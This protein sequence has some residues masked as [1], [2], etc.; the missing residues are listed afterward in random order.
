[1]SV[2]KQA[3]VLGL[4]GL[5][6]STV[7]AEEVPL[8]AA[9]SVQ[10][11][12]RDHAGAALSR[13]KPEV[14]FAIDVEIRNEA[15]AEPPSGLELYGWLRRSSAQNLPCLQAARGYFGTGRL[16]LDAVPLIG[17]VVG[18]LSEDDGFTVVDPFLDLAS[19][20]L[21]GATT[22]AE[23]P[24]D[25]AANPAGAGFLASLTDA[26]E[27]RSILAFGGETRLLAAGLA[28]PTTVVPDGLGGVWV[29][30]S[31]AARVAHLD[32]RGATVATHAAR[33]IDQSGAWVMIEAPDGGLTV[34]P[35]AGGAKM[36][37]LPALPDVQANA[38][39]VAEGR[40]VAAVRLTTEALSIAYLDAPAQPVTIPLGSPATELA[41]DAAGHYAFVWDPE[42]GPVAIVDLVRGRVVQEAGAEG[43]NA[44]IAEILLDGDGAYLMRADQTMVGALSLASITDDQ[45]LQIRR[46]PLGQPAAPPR[47]GAGLLAALSPRS[48]VLA[49]HSASFTGF[50]LHRTSTMG[51]APP[52]ASVK[53]RG[54]IPAALRVLDRGFRETGPGSFRAGAIL[55]GPGAF[56]LV[57]TTGVGGMT[58]CTPVPSEVAPDRISGPGR[59]RVL[60]D[61]PVGGDT[62]GDRR[63]VELSFID[64]EGKALADVSGILS[65][66]ALGTGWI[67]RVA[68]SDG[69]SVALSLP[70]AGP[71][72][73]TLLSGDGRDFAP[74]LFEV[75]P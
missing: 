66:N 39:M 46:I 33:A 17:P 18:V 64:A 4:L 29:L 36:A 40:A 60:I 22:F 3:G 20:N 58:V 41:V 6:A 15:G 70:A 24:A 1:M 12:F 5:L 28:Q 53:L 14:A 57:L 11:S 31:G 42:G 74:L 9:L 63:R 30:E 38:L 72:V 19:A 34:W 48:E 62:A 35:L 43:P 7:C 75:T 69:G 68:I 59:I 27:L 8:K 37:S 61:D 71:F 13:I 52:M 67:D 23:T 47:P 26:G 65:L 32:G 54:G 10:V 73:A 21:I 16:P 44:A 56:E 55:P 25:I 49:V 45:P 50:I 51:D 2:L